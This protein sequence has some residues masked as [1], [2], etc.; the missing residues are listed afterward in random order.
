MAHLMNAGTCDS[1][2]P[3]PT[4]RAFRWR[5]VL[6]VLVGV[7]LAYWV[8]VFGLVACSTDFAAGRADQIRRTWFP[9]EA[10]PAE[11][12]RWARHFATWDAEHYLYLSTHGY[13]PE[14]RSIAF[15]PLW[16]VVVRAMAPLAGGNPILAG[17]VL[18]NLF[19]LAG[20]VLFHRL[21]AR[22]FG[23]PVAD[24]ALA[25]LVAFPGALFFQFVYSESLFFLLLMGL[26]GGLELRRWT[27]AGAAALLL[28]LTR[29][30]GV[31]AVLPIGWQVL[32]SR[33]WHPFSNRF[34]GRETRGAKSRETPGATPGLPGREGCEL[35]T[36]DCGL[37]APPWALLAAPLA[38][39]GVYLALMGQWTSNPW[40]GIEAQKYWGVHAIANLWDVPKFVKGFFA[41]TAWHEFRG[42]LLDRLGFLL[43]LYALP[44]LWRRGRDLLSWVLMLAV[45]PAMSGTFTSYTRFAACAFPV[46]LAG[47]A[48]LGTGRR[49]WLLGGMLVV[50]GGLH[51]FLLWRFLNYHWAG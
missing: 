34:G 18:A 23:E 38:G 40:A 15:Y 8:V 25:L 13:A 50:S 44:V 1:L 47:G 43:A 51:L 49:R 5:R 17:L 4:P 37:P 22:R 45:I 35:R 27:L 12:G 36:S 6:L 9:A 48:V 19:S 3:G 31:F 41:V 21:S 33:H 10:P 39:W 30:V 20:W 26:W 7:K 14:V 29:G 42:S 11:H 46:F 24:A 28:P 32:A 16:P 2:E